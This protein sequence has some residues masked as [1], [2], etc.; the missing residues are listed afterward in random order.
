MGLDGYTTVL[1][2]LAGRFDMVPG[3]GQGRV[4]HVDTGDMAAGQGQRFRQDSATASDIQKFFAPNAGAS[5]DILQTQGIDLMQGFQGSFEI[6]PIHGVT[7]KMQNFAGVDIS[8]GCVHQK[9]F[10]ACVR[11]PFQN[12]SGT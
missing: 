6:P 2:L 5:F 3:G 11:I 4:R 1:N 9:S 12:R 7:V 10:I 8:I